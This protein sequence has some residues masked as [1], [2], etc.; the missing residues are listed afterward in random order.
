MSI[1]H[2]LLSVFTFVTALYYAQSSI[3]YKLE[4]GD[5]VKAAVM[6]LQQTAEIVQSIAL[7]KIITI[8]N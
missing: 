1:K 4:L 8:Y 2:L 3:S 7:T 6:A 5:Y